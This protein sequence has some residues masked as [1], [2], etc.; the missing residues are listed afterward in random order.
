AV[1]PTTDAR[2]K[3]LLDRAEVRA[4]TGRRRVAAEDVR[5]AV[6]FAPHDTTALER[7]GEHLA[8]AGDLAGAG[9]AYGALV[10][11]LRSEG[12]ARAGEARRVHLMLADLHERRGDGAAA[13]RALREAL[14]IEPGDGATIERLADLCERLDDARGAVEQL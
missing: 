7:L 14:A 11:R 12:T 2:V 6:G 3:L 10:E 13:A 8:A 9:A 5:A 1:A 4:R